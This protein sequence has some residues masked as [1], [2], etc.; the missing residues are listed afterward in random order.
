MNPDR[1][2][3]KMRTTLI[4]VFSLIL[5]VSALMWYMYQ[6]RRVVICT[7]EVWNQVYLQDEHRETQLKINL[8]NR[9]FIPE[10]RVFPLEEATLQ[11]MRSIC[12][13]RSRA[14]FL[15]SPYLSSLQSPQELLQAN[16][17]ADYILWEAALPGSLNTGKGP[18]LPGDESSPSVFLLYIDQDTLAEAYAEALVPLL[19]DGTDAV[20]GPP[21]TVRLFY[22]SR[23]RFSA[24]EVRALKSKIEAELAAVRLRTVDMAESGTASADTGISSGD[25]A[26][27]AGGPADDLQQ[28][29]TMIENRGARAVVFGDGADSGWPEGVAAEIS[30]D[31]EATLLEL[32]E[33]RNS[34]WETAV[35]PE[36]NTLQNPAVQR[37][38]VRLRITR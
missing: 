13:V 10:K 23:G 22:H 5:I 37:F 33:K 31:L 36:Q 19:T 16:P 2:N 9:F 4:A 15:F 7:D 30:I 18:D 32:I 20:Q 28:L 35:Q 21:R 11:Q 26:V 34:L 29:L 8:W 24:S 27:L 12:G 38:A 1:L 17:N 14:V 6:F 3:S 25:I